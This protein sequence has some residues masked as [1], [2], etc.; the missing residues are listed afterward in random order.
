MQLL[1]QAGTALECEDLAYLVSRLAGTAV[2]S[3]LVFSSVQ[4]KDY[5]I[6]MR[7]IK[8][9]TA[10]INTTTALKIKQFNPSCR[11]PYAILSH[12]WD[13]EE[14]SFAEVQS[15]RSAVRTRQ[16]F[17]KIVSFCSNA[18]KLGYDY[19]WVDTCCI[20]KRNSAELSEAINSMYQYYKNAAVCIV[21]LSDVT[22]QSNRAE[23]LKSVRASRWLSRGW[24]LQELIAPAARLFFDATWN[25]IRDG[26]AVLHEI[27]E[28]TGLPQAVLE[29]SNEVVKFC[30]AQRMSWDSKRKT[31]REEDMAYC[32]MGLF[33]IHMSPIYGEGG[34]NAFRRLQ[35]AIM[36]V[37]FDQ[38][39][40]AWKGPYEESGLL[41]RAPSDF[42]GSS[43]VSIWGPRYLSPYGM[44]NVGLSIR[45][46][47]ISAGEGGIEDDPGTV[48][49]L[50]QS[51]VV[52][53][54]RY[55]GLAVFLKPVEGAY[56]WSNGSRQPAYRRVR[57]S[58]WLV[59]GRSCNS[60][61]RDILVLEDSHKRLVESARFSDL[62]RWGRELLPPSDR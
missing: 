46:A 17:R 26:K 31:T 60:P 18:R 25:L 15:N 33:D 57:C 38:T 1:R 30:A 56:F 48:R 8:T 24:T 2:L 10:C 61:F 55:R 9:S 13:D 27:Q 42:H 54:G 36:Q 58:E 53:D 16:G 12:T 35:I 49:A 28:A 47:D 29:N 19:A 20:D 41:A 5:D 51:D 43:G 14:V 59:V 62:D 45:I 6:M 50:V 23:L 39:L 52:V 44:T 7:L 11:P 4:P 32:L 34:E 3:V 22:N 37:S 40:F 21:H